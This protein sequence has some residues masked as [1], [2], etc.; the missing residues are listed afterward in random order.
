[1]K[2]LF[3][4]RATSLCTAKILFKALSFSELLRSCFAV[5]SELFRY[6]GIR[7]SQRPIRLN[8]RVKRRYHILYVPRRKTEDPCDFRRIYIVGVEQLHGHV[9]RIHSLGFS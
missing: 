1:M 9:A 5:F 4:C 7:V 8:T 3:D 2:Y 6:F